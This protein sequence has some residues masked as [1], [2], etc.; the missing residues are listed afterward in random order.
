MSINV[1]TGMDT[2]GQKDWENNIE[3]EEDKIEG[4]EKEEWKNFILAVGSRL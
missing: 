1:Q 3:K 2:K 4:K